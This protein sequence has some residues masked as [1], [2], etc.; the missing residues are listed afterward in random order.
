M[1]ARTPVAATES[2]V[3]AAHVALLV[4]F[5]LLV[6][7]PAIAQGIG[8]PFL[9]ATFTRFVIYAIA[10]V[11]LDLILGIGGLMSFGHAAWFG[12]GGYV[13]AH[14]TR[15]TSRT[16]RR[17]SAGAAAPRRWSSGRSPSL[18]TALVALPIGALSLRTCGIHFIMI[19]L[20]FAQMLFYLFVSV[21]FYGGDDGLSMQRRNTLAGL[22]PARRHRLLL[23]LP[24]LP[25]RVDRR[26]ARRSSARASAWCCPAAGRASGACSALGYPVY[27]YKLVAFVLAAAGAAL[28]G[29]LWANRGRFVSPDMLAWVKS[30]ELM[31]M[32]ILGGTGTLVGP[33]VGAFALL[34]VEQLL[35]GWTEHW[36]LILG[37]LLVLFVVFARR[38]LW[39][40]VGRPGAERMAEPL[41][42]TT[43]LDQALRR[44]EG[45]RRRLAGRRRRRGARDHRSQRRRQDHAD[46]A[47][48][49]RAA[50]R[51]AEPSAS[52]A[53]TSP[54]L[55]T[56]RRTR[57]RPRPLLPDHAR[58]CRR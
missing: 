18:V 7:L 56:W 8:Q 51:R 41:L 26:C 12:L 49:R 57:L 34:G 44:A 25:G 46:R 45:D 11:S 23:R 42:E 28:A 1:D 4:L 50:A 14:R 5:L 33:I 3:V 6:A 53:T 58:C 30:G 15:S 43:G 32:V 16:A 2:G 35:S 40:L 27:R 48:H 20:A 55:P 13:V 24:R 54:R 31:V 52:T 21:K 9:I 19:T 10:A 22:R 29:A 39:G 36:M 38:G 37:P 47:A 17:S